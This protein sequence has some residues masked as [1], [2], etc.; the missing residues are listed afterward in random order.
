MIQKALFFCWLALIC[1]SCQEKHTS[2]EH[3]HDK[4]QYT[5]PMH[6]EILKDEPGTCP[7]CKMDLVKVESHAPKDSTHAHEQN[8]SSAPTLHTC[9]MHPEIV[10][11]QPGICPICKMDLVKMETSEPE[12][13]DSME[14]VLQPSNQFVVSSAKAVV[15]QYVD[16]Q[17]P[18][19]AE[20][21]ITYDTR[22][23]QNIAPRYAGRIEKLY[24]K[25]AY[26]PVNK[27]DRLFDIYSPDAVND[28]HHL[29]YILK[30]DPDN[31]SLINQAK[32]RLLQLGVTKEQI[33]H[34][35]KT[36]EP[37][38]LIRVFSPETG[39]VHDPGNVTS[40]GAMGAEN[41]N[42]ASP[43]GSFNLKEGSYVDRGKTVLSLLVTNRVWVVVKVPTDEAHKIK[44]G[45]KVS[46]QHESNGMEYT[47]KIS[48]VYPFYQDNSKFMQFRID[49]P[50]HHHAFRIGEFVNVRIHSSS[51][52]VLAIPRTSVVKLGKE[53]VVFVK[54]TGG[55]LAQPVTLGPAT[56][57][58]F[59]VVSGISE[60]DSIARN[61]GYLVDSESF[62]RSSN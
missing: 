58:Y 39:H 55:F 38:Y 10:R 3:G 26:Q 27:G 18:L 50:N 19:N 54:K 56:Q 5:C 1:L 9:P 37:D 40:S 49:V 21:Y 46:I 4:E 24:V 61:A 59:P 57:G 53:S 17:A 41:V 32:E 29:V 8:G 30:N 15:P 52:H 43:P 33:Q 45:Q 23:I 28:S 16:L 25:Y 34:M 42:P 36:L 11:D 14:A 7:I 13:V 20:G 47:S 12:K 6:P 22:E 62:I 35:E 44:L 48:F 51:D 31:H 2:H 60:T